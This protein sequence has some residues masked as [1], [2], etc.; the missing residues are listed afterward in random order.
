MK[1]CERLAS[2]PLEV[3]GKTAGVPAKRVVVGPPREVAAEEFKRCDD[4]CAADKWRPRAELRYLHVR[5]QTLRIGQMKYS[6][7]ILAP[8]LVVTGGVEVAEPARA[9]IK[10]LDANRRLD[11]LDVIARACRV[12]KMERIDFH[13]SPSTSTANV[14]GRAASGSTP[15]VCSNSTQRS[16][17]QFDS[18]QARSLRCRG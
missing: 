14:N 12:G 11:V 13:W 7:E 9:R 3:S 6:C 5:R 8:E 18:G 15:N 2:N 16:T 10:R 17:E 1:P 4:E